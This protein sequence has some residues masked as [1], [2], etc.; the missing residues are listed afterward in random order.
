MKPTVL[1]IEDSYSIRRLL[2]EV[3]KTQYNVL[4]AETAEIGMSVIAATKVDIILLDIML[5][6]MDGIEFC[7]W[8]KST[9]KFSD[10]PVIVL[11]AKTGTRSRT[12]AYEVGASNFLEKPFDLSELQALIKSTLRMKDGVLGGKISYL[13]LKLDR[14]RRSISIHNELIPLTP[15]EF[16]VLML[17]VRNAETIVSRDQMYETLDSGNDHEGT[18]LENYISSI[19]K[20]IEPRGDAVIKTHYGLGYQLIKK[21]A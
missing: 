1:L 4:E 13:S 2:I 21:A 17:L 7:S 19:R 9:D 14:E 16:D 20:K 12:F 5:P 3:L 18:R 8:L 10:V 6:Q 15:G 11:S